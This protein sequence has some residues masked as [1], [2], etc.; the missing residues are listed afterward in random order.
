MP[1]RLL[2][3][4]VGEPWN[5]TAWV[6]TLPLDSFCLI[7]GSQLLGTLIS[8]VARL[9]WIIEAGL[10][11]YHKYC[12]YKREAEQDLMPTH[13][14][15]G[16]VKMVQRDIWRYWP[17]RLEWYSHKLRNAGSHLKLQEATNWFS[18][19]TRRKLISDPDSQNCCFKPPSLWQ[20]VTAA[21]G[22]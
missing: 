20:F 1:I 14:G 19:L 17:W 5:Q 22:I 13:R 8:W 15:E 11:L 6:Q 7:M 9:A 16:D 2:C 10:E 12:L 3:K 21:V 4:V 18:P